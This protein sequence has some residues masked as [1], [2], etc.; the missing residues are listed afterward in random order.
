MILVPQRLT[1]LNVKVRR[2]GYICSI[3]KILRESTLSTTFLA[4]R[5]ERWAIEN[6]RHLV[7]YSKYIPFHRKKFKIIPGE[8]TPSPKHNASL[9]YIKTTYELNLITKI[10][11]EWRNTKYGDI[12]ACLESNKNPF[13]LSLSQICFLLKIIL[14]SDYD[15]IRSIAS[16]ISQGLLDKEERWKYFVEKEKEFLLIKKRQT[17]NVNIIKSI[18]K[19]LKHL[20]EWRRNPKKY[21]LENIEAPRIEWLWDLKIINWSSSKKRIYL[22]SIKTIFFEQEILSEYWLQNDYYHAFHKAF[23]EKILSS[24]EKIVYWNDLDERERTELINHYLEESYRLF[25]SKLIWKIA[26][27]QF[28]EYTC[29]NLLCRR[30]I[31]TT[32]EDVERT[33]DKLSKYKFRKMIDKTDIGFIVKLH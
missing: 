25:G 33:L 2:L 8:I 15:R 17:D 19:A 1:S 27:S 13:E 11:E 29:C 20:Q 21:Y 22:P 23:K 18:D 32:F 30:G 28:F 3:T 5:L 10:G 31:V 24:N 12:L 14:K 16:L 6:R 7:E 9:R 4:Q 26:A